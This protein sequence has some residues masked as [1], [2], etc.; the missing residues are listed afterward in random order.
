[1]DHP[2]LDL[3]SMLL[4]FTFPQGFF[5][6]YFAYIFWGHRSSRMQR[7]ILL[8]ACI[9][10]V[11]AALSMNLIPLSLRP[12]ASFGGFLLI[13]LLVFRSISLRY[14]L[15]LYVT[16]AFL[17]VLVEVGMHFLITSLGLPTTP[18]L[19]GILYHLPLHLAIGLAAFTLDRRK[20]SSGLR[21]SQSL[22][23]P[24]NR[25]MFIM[26]ILIC[27]NFFSATVAYFY[28]TADHPMTAVFVL[29]FSFAA[30]II[31]LILAFR[32]VNKEKDQAL[33]STQDSY[34][35]EMNHLFTVIRG[36]RHDFLNHVQVIKEFA[37]QGKLDDMEKYTSELVGEI[38]EINDLIQINHPALAALIKSKMMYSMTRRI[39]FRYAFEGM[40]GIDQ[41][42]ASID[43]VKIVGNLIDNALEEVLRRPVEERWIEVN[44]WTDEI[45][46]YFSISNP[47][48][49]LTEVDK[50]KLFLP[51]Y[52]TKSKSGNSGIGLSIVSERVQY[53]NGHIHIVSDE[54]R[55]LEFQVKLPLRPR[56]FVQ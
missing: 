30:S 54:D 46:V 52:S 45:N 4:L 14:R 24:K 21:I 34:V 25:S 3:L 19:V 22:Q 44:G 53:Y 10:T 28:L 33:L 55:V 41:G 40:S 29:C 7:E 13:T 31:I 56:T 43:Y 16:I 20:F 37:R 38:V 17:S 50:N 35:E 27:F 18:R 5:N 47:A 32:S 36:Q 11:L 51:G 15:R 39:Q 1:M 2:W 23:L 8:F 26:L 12:I 48:D 49:A 42:V 6:S 9:S